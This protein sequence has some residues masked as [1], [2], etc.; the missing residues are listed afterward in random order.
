MRVSELMT[1]RVHTIGPE[2]PANDAWELMR[3]RQIRHLVVMANS[4]IVGVLSDRDLGSR[5]GAGV[6]SDTTVADLMTRKV[7]TIGPTE[8]IRAA[9]NLMR[10]RTIGCLPVVERGRLAGVITV[11]DLLTLVGRGVDRPT[12]GTR[13]ATHYRVA[14]RKQHQAPRA[15]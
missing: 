2:V 11:S 10:G 15:W 3:R 14:H 12:P 7:V 6:R 1:K 4:T 9:A 5:R 8:T 13:A